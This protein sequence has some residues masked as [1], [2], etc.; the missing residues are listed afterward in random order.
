M[1]TADSNPYALKPW[2]GLEAY[3]PG[4][5]PPFPELLSAFR[6]CVRRAGGDPALAYF[7]SEFSYHWLDE[8]SDALASWLAEHA[9]LTRG[10]RVAVVLQNVPDFPVIT[11]AAWKIGAVVMPLNPMYRERELTHLF[12]DATPSVIVCHHGTGPLMK[13]SAAAAGLPAATPV[14][15]VSPRAHQSR[16]DS[17]VLPAEPLIDAGCLDLALIVGQC[18]A[19]RSQLRM[20]TPDARDP[21][22]LLY[23]SGTTGAPKAAILSHGAL[24]CDAYLKVGCSGLGRGGRIFSVAPLF[25]VIGFNLHMGVAW[26]TG[27]MLILT[28]RFQ[29]H[30]VL[31]TLLERRPTYMA[32][33]ITA[34]FALVATELATAEHFAS[35]QS[36]YSGGAPVPPHAVERFRQKFGKRIRTGYGMTE[37]SGASHAAPVDDVPVHAESGALAVG[38]PLPGIEAEIRTDDDRP[39][40]VGVAG[41][42]LV[43]G[44]ILMKG[45]W[46]RPQENAEALRDGW[47]RTGDIA[48][49]DAAGW[50]YIVDRKKDMISASGFKVWPR[51]VEDVLY[52][53][54]GVREVAVVGTPDDYRGETVVACISLFTGAAVTAAELT[55]FCRSRLAAFKIPTRIEFLAE[56][57]KTS[58][59]K[60][61]RGEVRR[62]MRGPQQ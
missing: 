18:Q 13:A 39:A 4:G 26:A 54:P 5:P 8:R 25:H 50:F 1:S 37:L 27:G 59:G 40:P 16:N 57:P 9:R 29:P 20:F 44:P 49:M 51:E 41:E 45:Y 14:L 53:Y 60:I 30:V 58:S 42:L 32:C 48:I 46:K 56:L 36:L 23:T 2:L 33:T 19:L 34:I 10:D 7:D 17:R 62:Q 12:A 11:L 35:L 21:A 28:Y 24:C 15:S 55:E 52:Q 43:R 31:E 38:V 3:P 61:M 22:L 6:H 47:L